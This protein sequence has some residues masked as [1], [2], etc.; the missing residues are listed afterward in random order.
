MVA[1][2]EVAITDENHA[3]LDLRQRGCA[4]DEQTHARHRQR[5][6]ARRHRRRRL[7]KHRSV[8]YL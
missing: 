7:I 8:K 4:P 1:V 6:T 5:K 3:D 2:D